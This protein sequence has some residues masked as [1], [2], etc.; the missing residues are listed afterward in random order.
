MLRDGSGVDSTE[1]VHLLDL[2]AALARRRPSRVSPPSN[3]GVKPWSSSGLD[4]HITA[5]FP[6]GNAVCVRI[7]PRMIKKVLAA[8]HA[9]IAL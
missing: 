2:R 1:F 6:H 7:S 8:L 9:S 5:L 4:S 3:G